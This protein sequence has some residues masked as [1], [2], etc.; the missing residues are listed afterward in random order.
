VNLLLDTRVLLW[1]LG[2]DPQLG[3]AARE[4]I[5]QPDNLVFMSAVSVWEIVVK[6]SVGKLDV[7]DELQEVLDSQPFHYLDMTAEHAFK[8]GELP[9]H[10]RDPFD[11]LLIAQSLVDGLT[12]VTGDSNIKKYDVPVLEA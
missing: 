7:P 3:Q 12:L 10:H 5:A 1:W 6:K 8:V 4:V 2:D 11:R 9:L